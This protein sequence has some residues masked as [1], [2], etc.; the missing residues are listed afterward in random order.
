MAVR[1]DIYLHKRF[2]F[3]NGTVGKKFAIL[4]NTPGLNEP[5]LFVKTTSQEKNKS[6]KQGCIKKRQLF[7]IAAKTTFFEKDT[8]VQLYELYEMLPENVDKH[9]DVKRVGSLSLTLIEDIV[10]CLLLLREDDIIPYQQKL[11]KP[12]LQESLE[13]LQE[14]FRKKH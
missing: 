5:Y 3:H 4:L 10:N 2:K 9:T 11:L 7:F 8:W 12:A 14:K 13:K 6:S 1:G